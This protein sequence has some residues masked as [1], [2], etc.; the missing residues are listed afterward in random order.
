MNREEFLEYAAPVYQAA[1]AVL[2]AVP[3]DR[4]DYAPRAGMLT[5]GQVAMHIGSAC[6]GA[7]QFVAGGNFPPMT[8]KMGLPP[9]ESFPTGTIAEAL[10]ALDADE[11]LLREIVMGWTEEQFQHDV[12]QEP[13][14]PVPTT[15]WKLCLSMLD[16][17]SG[18]KMQL[19][20]YLRILG[21]DVNTW[22]LF[23]A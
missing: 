9:G 8:E 5:I 14:S 2:K 13:W 21:C 16:H 17:L 3:A 18:H 11:K 1:R 4:L 6:A 10:A 22:T 20:Q 15:N 19:F 12:V 23:G 7:I